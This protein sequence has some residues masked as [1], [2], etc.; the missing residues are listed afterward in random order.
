MQTDS[1]EAPAA[2]PRR[3]HFTVAD[4]HRMVAMGML[5]SAGAVELIDGDIID[6]APMS[7]ARC[8]LLLRLEGLLSRAVGTA[9]RVV[10]HTAIGL[11]ADCE[12]R[13]DVMVLR[14]RPGER[15]GAAVAEDLVLVIEVSEAGH[16]DY[17]HKVPCYARHGVAEIWLFDLAR[18]TVHFFRAP[19]DGQYTDEIA[20][21]RPGVIF[22]PGLT[23][24]AVDLRGTLP[25]A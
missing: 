19:A 8:D 14:G 2:P 20:T 10:R 4:A 9:A 24:T 3:H 6:R 21:D 17:D 5:A 15:A 25:T 23:D 22:L 11:G 1:T 18:A 7:P 16:Y 12:P 13:P